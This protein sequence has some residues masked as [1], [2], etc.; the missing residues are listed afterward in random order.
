MA[1]SKDRYLTVAISTTQHHTS[2]HCQ[3][4]HLVDGFYVT[5]EL[6]GWPYPLL[7]CQVDTEDAGRKVQKN[8][9][10]NH[11]YHTINETMLPQRHNHRKLKM[12]S[13][14]K[15]N[16]NCRTTLVFPHFSFLLFWS[17]T[18]SSV[19]FWA[20]SLVSNNNACRSNKNKYHANDSTMF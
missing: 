6:V 14:L 9:R 10:I 11:I 1:A 2:Y 18:S 19:L 20:K 5:L 17:S 4:N 3:D 16:W 12:P 8:T 7:K 13:Q 15:K